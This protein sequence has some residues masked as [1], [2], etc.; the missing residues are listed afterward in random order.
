MISVF[1]ISDM[2][3]CKVRTCWSNKTVFSSRPSFSRF[4]LDN[5]STLACPDSNAY[6]LNSLWNESNRFGVHLYGASR[7]FPGAPMPCGG[8]ELSAGRP[9]TGPSRPPPG[10]PERATPKCIQNS[11]GGRC[12][13]GRVQ[14]D[15][16]HFFTIPLAR[17]IA[18]RRLPGWIYTNYNPAD[19][20][21]MVSASL[22]SVFVS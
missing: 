15:H 12:Y 17:T 6:F 16:L 13:F 19:R 20:M 21:R 11:H 2:D 18:S 3:A 22:G 7:I 8:P 10:G 4:I 1:W 5:S 9:A 14:S